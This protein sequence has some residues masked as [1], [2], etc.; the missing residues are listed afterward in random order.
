LDNARNRDRHH[1]SSEHGLPAVSGSTHRKRSTIKVGSF[2]GAGTAAAR[3]SDAVGGPRSQ[4]G[5][6]FV[7]TPPD[8]F[9][10]QARD[11]R[12]PLETA[13]PQPLGLPRRHPTTL[14]LVQPAQHQIELPVIIPFGMIT[15]PTGDAATLAN[16]QF[17]GHDLTPTL[18]CPTAYTE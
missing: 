2:I 17:Y 14:L 15:R 9:R 11:L 6:E 18:E 5:G 4:V 12:D 3:K 10:M 13:I 7:P 16:R 8:R 1:F